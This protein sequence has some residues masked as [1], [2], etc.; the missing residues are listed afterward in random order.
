MKSGVPP[1][2]SVRG[3]F[4][5]YGSVRALDGVDLELLPGE[6][7]GI[8]GENGA[9]KSTLMKI[10]AGV[11]QP[12]TGQLL[13][14]GTPV[15]FQSVQ[16]ALQL[17]IVMIHQELN[18][19]D[20]LSVADNIFLGREPVRFGLIDRGRCASE[21]SA[22]LHRIGHDLDPSRLVY[23][24]S[25]ADKQMVEIAKALSYQASVLIMD[26]PTATL[27]ERDAL[28]LLA[29]IGQLR[30]NGVTIV[31]IS[32]I[33]PQ[34]LQVSDRI[35]VLRD[36]KVVTTLDNDQVK[37]TAERELAS[38]MVGRPM[39]EY[40]PPRKPHGE[41][42][43][44]SVE[45]L[46]VP[47][48]AYNIHF[49]VRQGEIF[50]LA[51][52]IGAGRTETAEAIVGLRRRSSGTFRLDGKPITID[53]PV[54]AARLGIAYLPEDRKD[55]GLTL[56]MDVIDNTTMVSMARYGRV[57][58]DRRGQEKAT[59]AHASRLHIRAGSLNDSVSTLS[60]GNQQKVLLAKWLEIAPRVLIVDEP[61]RG[62]DIGAKEEIYHLLHDLAAQ[63]M[64]CI[65][66]S[67]EMNEL[68]GLCHRIGVMRSGRLVTILDGPSA[69][70]DQ[71]IHA[72]G[73]EATAAV[74][75]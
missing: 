32:H 16:D 56:G 48:L 36:G 37:Q 68:L 21:A 58:I 46:S 45:N 25:I 15:Q 5:Q 29:L 26:E 70:E 59:Q 52:L 9:G 10:L 3:L 54:D 61:T 57:L 74:P 38:L 50:G 60:G 44:L 13:V 66:I 73:L 1:A 22:L 35:T 63:G 2:V 69:T 17:G 43:V 41:S 47:Q 20:E 34:V 39:A 18:L 65:M 7:H 75:S 51:G 49:E 11:Q 23:T 62:V 8:V 28:A 55:A 40:F 30:S 67:S 19:V 72:A 14:R 12:T 64:T 31:F 53:S 6:V 71:I 27:T 4:K 33:L 24:L 42:V